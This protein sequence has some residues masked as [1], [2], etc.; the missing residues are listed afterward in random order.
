[1]AGDV[2]DMMLDGT[3]CEACGSYM[4]DGDP[5]GF[6]GY[7]SAL[8]AKDRG[9]DFIFTDEECRDYLNDLDPDERGQAANYLRV[10][11]GVGKK[12]ATRLVAQWRPAASPADGTPS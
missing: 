8:C 12:R 9:A 10:F 5:R 4:G 3:L 11:M 7:C 6:P 2:A 1:M